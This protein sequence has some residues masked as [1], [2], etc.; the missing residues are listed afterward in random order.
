MAD[1]FP[2]HYARPFRFYCSNK[3]S[4]HHIPISINFFQTAKLVHIRHHTIHIYKQIYKSIYIKYTT[5]LYM[6]IYLYLP[7]PNNYP[8]QKATLRP[9]VGQAGKRGSGMKPRGAREHGNHT[10]N[11]TMNVNKN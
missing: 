7:S 5:D 4:A 11:L 8:I 1:S 3:H 2:A 6:H 10:R 9:K